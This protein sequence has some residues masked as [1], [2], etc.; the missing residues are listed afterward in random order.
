MRHVL[1]P[2]VATMLVQAM[3]AMAVSVLPVL[4]ETY[5]IES[6]LIGIYASLV[7]VGAIVCTALGDCMAAPNRRYC[8]RDADLGEEPGMGSRVSR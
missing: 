4:A 1:R 8:R 7:F 5:G 6:S 3:V 2:L